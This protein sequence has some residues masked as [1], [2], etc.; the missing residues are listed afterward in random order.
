MGGEGVYINFYVIGLCWIGYIST[1][2]VSGN[3]K[4]NS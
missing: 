2:E 3:D 4:K 1:D